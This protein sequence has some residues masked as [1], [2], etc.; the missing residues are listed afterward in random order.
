MV[1]T[2]KQKIGV[3]DVYKKSL[4]SPTSVVMLLEK[5]CTGPNVVSL[6]KK[7]AAKW[8]G[9]TV[10]RKRIFLMATQ[11][12][13]FDEASTLWKVSGNIYI[14]TG[15]EDDLY[16]YLKE[17]VDFRKELKKSWSTASLEFLGWW[18]EKSRKDAEYVNQLSAIPSK[19]V[20]IGKLLFMIQYPIQWLAM[21]LDQYAKIKEENPAE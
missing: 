4:V 9:V 10:V 21:V 20:L 18:Y 16:G 2:R 17:V 8:V 13:W 3:V 15:P 7:L 1:L 12:E 11:Q 5:G 14:L 19:E 6:R